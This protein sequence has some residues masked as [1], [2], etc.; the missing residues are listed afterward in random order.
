MLLQIGFGSAILIVS[1]LI[2]VAFVSGAIAFLRRHASQPSR[3]MGISRISTTLVLAT[4]WLLAAQ[5]VS[6][7]LWSFAF[8]LLGIFDSLEPAIYF[9]L[10]TY[11]TLG[12]GDITLD[13]DWRIL[14]GMTAVNGLLMFGFST[15]FLFEVY[16]R[17]RGAVER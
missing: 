2:H 9:T 7:W 8:L 12:Y 14:S 13:A 1:I 15:A 10:V 5:T 6:V 4:I 3:I 11:T 17:M 16:A